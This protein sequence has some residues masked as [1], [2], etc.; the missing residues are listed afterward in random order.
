MSLLANLE[1][2]LD[3]TGI[4]GFETDAQAAIR[5]IGSLDDAL[6]V[7]RLSFGK[8][9]A[10]V[11]RAMAPIAHTVVPVLHGII[12]G[13]T[14]F[15]NDAGAV[16]AALFG[17]VRKEVKTTSTATGKAIRN[18]LAGFDQLER[19]GGSTGGGSITTQVVEEAKALTPEL[20][21]VVDKIRLLLKPLQE[22]DFTPAV[23]AF[24]RLQKAL[25]PWKEELFSGLKWAWDNLLVP[26]SRWTIEEAAPA[27]LELLCAALEALNAVATALKPVAVWLWEEFLQPLG[28]WAG[29]TILAAMESLTEKLRAFGTWVSENEPLV[30]DFVKTALQLAAAW[31]GINGVLS[32]FSQLAPGTTSLGAGL[33]NVLG[34]LS[35]SA[36]GAGVAI[37]GVIAALALLAAQWSTTKSG[38]ETGFSGFGNTVKATCNAIIG[39]IN[40]L[41]S[42]VTAGINGVIRALNS[43]QFT[44][45]KWVPLLGGESLGFHI[46]TLT[47][48]QIPYLAQGAVLPA[49][50]PFLAMVGDQRHGTNIEAPLQTIQQAVDTV[51]SDRFDGMM[52]GFQAVVRAIEEKNTT[53]S[54]DGREIWQ[55]CRGYEAKY[56]AMTGGF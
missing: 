40:R 4:N 22:I 53:L 45:P 29:E 3:D 11:E 48:P 21:A 9:R 54:L 32:V 56:D 35:G 41:L 15:V 47:A 37:A 55:A 6:L 46:P 24:H 28:K 43:L 8:L 49:N 34:S 30:Q 17:T 26:L 7:L 10:A 33:G 50:K 44:V 13:I 52:A 23:E 19:L 36:D 12:R 39:F 2:H 27:F 18:T 14:D 20:Q 42:G 25:E 51:L 31:V 16:I 5:T 1:L 38:V